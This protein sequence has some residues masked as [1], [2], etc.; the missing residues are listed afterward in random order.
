MGTLQSGEVYSVSAWASGL[1]MSLYAE[2]YLW[3]TGGGQPPSVK[4]ETDK[5]L[6]EALVGGI[7]LLFL[8]TLQLGSKAT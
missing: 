4:G 7:Y 8:R 1:D 3:C 6:I 5:D 2:C